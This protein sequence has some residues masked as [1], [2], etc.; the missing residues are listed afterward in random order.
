[1][2]AAASSALPLL[3]VDLD[4]AATADEALLLDIAET[5][6]YKV[7]PR[8]RAAGFTAENWG[9]EA[10]ALT[11]RLR[12]TS[13]ASTALVVVW[14]RAPDGAARAPPPA[15]AARLPVTLAPAAAGFL[16][17]AYAQWDAL[18]REGLAHWLEPVLDSSRYFVLRC[19][20]PPARAGADAAAQVAHVLLG[21]GFRQRETAFSLK[22]TLADFTRSA[23]RHAAGSVGANEAEI[24]GGG[25]DG[26]G[27]GGASAPPLPPRPADAPRRAPAAPSASIPILRAPRAAEAARVAAAQMPPEIAAEAATTATVPA[28][29]PEDEFGELRGAGD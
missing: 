20:A 11:A 4:A 12:V 28:A 22:A 7:P 29:A 9:L 6:I 10:P 27:G 19:A 16:V 18:G 3:A 25:G 23:A 24:G 15:V 13:Y 1:M 2:G 8:E 17:V 26:G 5:F 21:V 14:R